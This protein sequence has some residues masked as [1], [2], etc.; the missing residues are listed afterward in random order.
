MRPS[1]QLRTQDGAVF[2]LGHGDLIGRLWS[3]ALHL[4]D[5]WISEAHALVSLRGDALHLL[6]LRGRMRVGDVARDEVRLDPGVRVALAP[7]VS[8]EVVSVRLP[9]EVLALEAEG[10]GRRVL[11]GTC[12]LISLPRPAIVPLSQEGIEAMVWRV[13]S[14]WRVRVVGGDAKPLLAGDQV[15]LGG[16]T[17]TAVEVTVAP[18]AATRRQATTDSRVRVVARYDSVH[19]FREG[20]PPWTL[21]GV[22]ARLTSELVRFGVPVT[23]TMLAAELWPE[24]SGDPVAQRKRLDAALSRL[25]ARL[26]EGDVRTDLVRFTGAGSIELFLHAGD[27]VEDLT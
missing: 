10:L 19:V 26:S 3:A 8:V 23:W 1:V 7:Q 9:D 22:P 14:G 11:H 5:P 27:T 13:A 20:A 6:A 2:D 21:G 17:F 4:D 15:R 25:R 18:T 12:G 24:G 16:A